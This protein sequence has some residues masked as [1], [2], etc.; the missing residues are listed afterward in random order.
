MNEY[1]DELLLLIMKR[2]ATSKTQS[3]V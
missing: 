2:D 1:I 3:A